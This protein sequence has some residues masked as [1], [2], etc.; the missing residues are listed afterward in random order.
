MAKEGFSRTQCRKQ[1]I[2]LRN[3]VP[4]SKKRRSGVLSFLGIKRW[5]LRYKDTRQCFVETTH[6]AAFLSKMALQ[7]I[8]RHARDAKE[9][10]HLHPT[11]P[12][13]RLQSRLHLYPACHPPQPVTLLELNL[14]KSSICRLDIHIRIQRFPVRNLSMMITRSV[15]NRSKFPGRS[16]VQLHLKPDRGNGSSHTKNPDLWKWAC[17][18]TKNPA[19]QVHNFRSN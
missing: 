19:F 9:Q 14:L 15:S 7:T 8:R 18:T 6:P 3:H 12:E 10:V 1:N 13:S 2:S 16:R 17:F 11:D 4:R 5:R